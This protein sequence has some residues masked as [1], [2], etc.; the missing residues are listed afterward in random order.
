MR[1]TVTV[2]G[3]PSGNENNDSSRIGVASSLVT[4]AICQL[5]P[6][7]GGG[8]LVAELR[9]GE[10][11]TFGIPV[12][13]LEEDPGRVQVPA[14]MLRTLNSTSPVD[15]PLSFRSLSSFPLGT[16]AVLQA[17]QSRYEEENVEG[18]LQEALKGY[19]VLTTGDFVVGQG[20]KG[21][22]RFLVVA[23]FSRDAR[24]GSVQE[25]PS[26]R[27]LNTDLEL[28]FQPPQDAWLSSVN[29]DKFLVE[30]KGDP[31]D[32]QMMTFES[33]FRLGGTREE[34]LQAMTSRGRKRMEGD[35]ITARAFSFQGEGRRLGGD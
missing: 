25:S 8:G 5:C 28:E 32:G 9:H 22:F 35:R 12:E 34:L 6:G 23:L 7:G 24:R 2:E 10:R 11:H 1:R 3:W 20:S 19:H 14:W 31:T 18:M 15:L 27:V 16:K 17:E 4:D 30:E 26:V 13:P 21:T 33:G 29:A